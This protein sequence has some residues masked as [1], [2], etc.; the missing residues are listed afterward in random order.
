MSVEEWNDGLAADHDIDEYYG[1]SNPVVRAVEE[2]R[3]RRIRALIAPKPDERLLE[4]G[5]G[6]GHVLQRFPECDLVGIDVSGAMLEKARTRLAGLRVELHKGE[7]GDLDLSPGAF[8]AIVCTEVLEHVV[9]PDAVLAGIAGLLKPTGRAVVTFPND[10]III[11]A[12][13]VLKK[14]GAS[15]L[16]IFKRIDWGGDRYH[17]HAWT[18]DEMRSLLGRSFEI[19]REGHVPSRLVPVRCCF[20]VRPRRL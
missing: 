17:L 15:R 6:G 14:S 2:L 1:Q 16:P 11:G 9:D 19:S 10:S 12:K 4:V 8:D 5:C 18:V 20:L 13:R 7:L 3:L